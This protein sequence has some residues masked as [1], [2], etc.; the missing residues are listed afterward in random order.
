MLLGVIGVFVL[1]TIIFIVIRII[2]GDPVRVL[3]GIHANPELIQ[4][5]I[6]E[7]GLDKPLYEQY[8]DYMSR[9]LRGD[10]GKSL[11]TRRPVIET[12][13]RVLPVTLELTTVALIISML[14]GLVLGV[15]SALKKD[16]LT[17]FLLEF[18]A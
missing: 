3:F 6:R 7:L 13:V 5:T 11:V 10:L 17:D 2:P 4:E 16:S 14:I 8:I 18:F 15:I 12:I 9:L 1:L